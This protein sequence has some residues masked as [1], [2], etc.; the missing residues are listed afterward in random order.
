MSASM[1]ELI[2]N[3]LCVGAGG[4]VGA[5][6]RYL[7]GL[8]IPAHQSGFPLGTFAVNVI[9]AFAIAFIAT[10]FLRHVGLDGRLLLFLMTGVCGGFTTFSSFTWES[11][12][13]IQRG[14]V[15]VAGAYIVGSCALCLVA[16]LIGQ[17]LAMRLG[18]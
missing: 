4:C 9:G 18:A 12:Q 10:W 2:V 13:L 5:I 14:D 7:M 1:Q 17:Q 15:L 6:A 16:A 3:C 8:V 11:L